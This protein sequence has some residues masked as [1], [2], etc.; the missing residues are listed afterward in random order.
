M[1]VRYLDGIYSSVVTSDGLK[2]AINGYTDDV[3]D[4]SA[5]QLLSE[6]RANAVKEYLVKKGISS[7]RLDVQG[8]GEASPVAPNITEAGRK[9]N[10]RVQIVLLAK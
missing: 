4:P 3:G 7:N 8:F 10:R 9:Q 1:R 2:V 5:N 6:R